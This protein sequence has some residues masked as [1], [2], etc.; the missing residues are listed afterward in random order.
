MSVGLT[1][2]DLSHHDPSS[3][4]VVNAF[5]TRLDTLGGNPGGGRGGRGG[6]GRA[7]APSFYSVHARSVGQLT[8]QAN[9]V[10]AW[11]MLNAKELPVIN[12]ALVKG[13][14]SPLPRAAG[15]S[16]PKC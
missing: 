4:A 7:P 9:V 8:A 13:G 14:H 11:A 12:A 5:R 6:G 3:S 2:A 15:V 16:S 10:S 1:G